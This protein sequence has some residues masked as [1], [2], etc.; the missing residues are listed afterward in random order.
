M[1]MSW[2]LMGRGLP[3]STSRSRTSLELVLLLILS[4]C[5]VN[6][7]LPPPPHAVSIHAVRETVPVRSAGDAADDPAIWFNS[8]DPA[9]SLVFGTDKNFGLE[10]YDLQGRRRQSLAVGRVNNVDLRPLAGSVRWSALAAAS[11]RSTNSI[12]LF[13]IDQ[14]GAAVWL[15][16]S[17]IATGLTE[18]YGLCMYAGEAGLQVFVNDTDGRY[19]Q[20]LLTPNL[21][22]DLP[23]VTS[24]LLREFAVSLQPEGCVADDVMGRLFIGVEALGIRVLAA[25]PEQPAEMTSVADIDGEI[26]VADVEGMTL[27]VSGDSGYL[28]VS[29][30]GNDSYAVYE[31]SP[32]HRYRGSFIVAG[33]LGSNVDGTD[34]TDG[35]DASSLVVTDEFPEGLLVIQD[36]YNTLPARS[37]DFKYVSWA[38]VRA[39]LA[40]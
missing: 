32:P 17:E 33:S 27:L 19:Q 22:P 3:I 1:E 4:A 23:V 10:V 35:L 30:Q 40:L 20:W 5:A 31:R 18:P 14:M 36:G 25:T 37:Q 2:R 38:D 28:I 39:A 26:L 15:A 34:E 16:S 13:A 8:A 12:S 24:R 29:S 9:A 11:N 7:R 6:D 21:D